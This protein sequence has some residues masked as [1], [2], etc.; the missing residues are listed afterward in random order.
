MKKSEKKLVD[1]YLE[2]ASRE[3]HGEDSSTTAPAERRPASAR[4]RVRSRAGSSKATGRRA[5]GTKCSLTHSQ[6]VDII[7]KY[8]HRNEREWICIPEMRIGTG[9]GKA[10][11]R[12]VDLFAINCFPS[13]GHPTIAYEI[14]VSRADFKRDVAK[15]DKQRG[16]RLYANEFYYVAPAGILTKEDV[17][18]WAGL[19]EIDY[20]GEEPYLPT[21][22]PQ[23]VPRPRVVQAAFKQTRIRPSWS[24]ICSLLRRIPDA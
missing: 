21:L 24:F 8:Y 18:L 2:Q 6:V 11:S 4:S 20:P 3:V 23:S 1:N 12:Q 13:K 5:S 22:R 17:P 10:A 7:R 19:I 16:A 14:K 9:Y 15:P